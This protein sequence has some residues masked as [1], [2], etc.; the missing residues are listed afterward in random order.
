MIDGR[1]MIASTTMAASRPRAVGQMKHLADAR[2]EHEHAYETVDHR[3][4]AGKQAHG[5]GHDAADA[6]RG[7]LCQ[8][9]RRQKADRHAEH[10]R[11]R[12]A[13]YTCENERQD[14]VGRLR[15]RGRPRLA[16][17]ERMS[18]ICRMAGMPETIRYTLMSS[19]H[20]TVMR[21]RSKNTPCTTVSRA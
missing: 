7:D 12:G 17:Q 16:E 13:V 6:R 9:H 2:H 14:T 19:T 20:P 8:I 18:P 5:R 10:D 15:R 21:P 1:I 11:A 4:D 3:R